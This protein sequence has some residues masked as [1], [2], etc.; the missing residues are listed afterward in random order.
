MF[1]TDR[2]QFVIELD[3][4]TSRK[5]FIPNYIQSN[6]NPNTKRLNDPKLTWCVPEPEPTQKKL[7]PE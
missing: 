2:T 4:D 1:N 5:S 6:T 7:D 3:I